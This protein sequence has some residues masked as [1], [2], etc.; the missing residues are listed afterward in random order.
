MASVQ[1]RRLLAVGVALLLLG[2]LVPTA[3]AADDTTPPVGTLTVNHG[4]PVTNDP[5]HVHLDVPATDDLSG[6]AV[7]QLKVNGGGPMVIDYQPSMDIEL[8]WWRDGSN[9]IE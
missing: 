3:L 1:H 6:V 5:W 9:T 8:P 2:S 4:N 7:I